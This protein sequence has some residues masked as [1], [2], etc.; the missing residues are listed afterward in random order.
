MSLIDNQQH[1]NN[2]NSK[3]DL[4]KEHN[5]I[6][7]SQNQVDLSDDAFKLRQKNN[8]LNK[9]LKD[10]TFMLNT[11]LNKQTEENK[12][13]KLINKALRDSVGPYDQ[14]LSDLQIPN[15]DL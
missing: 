2:N 3:I 6:L 13:L 11:K 12:K 14:Y 7:T 1:V 8:E 5:N 15:N 10:I 9:K 4:I